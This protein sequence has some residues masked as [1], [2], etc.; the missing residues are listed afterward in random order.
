MMLNIALP[1]DIESRL[2]GEASRRG[3]A[4]EDYARKLIVEHLPPAKAI[5]LAARLAELAALKDGWLD[6]A[7][8][9]PSQADLQWLAATWSGAFPRDLPTPYA[10]PTPDGGIQLEWTTGPWELSAEIDLSARTAT[11]SKVNVDSSEGIEK[12]IDLK[13]SAGWDALRE[14][15]RSCVAG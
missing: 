8:R 12:G 2:K 13:N 9:A 11:L 6:G 15:V 10:Y 14:F 5:D 7:G 1:P 3:L 4:T